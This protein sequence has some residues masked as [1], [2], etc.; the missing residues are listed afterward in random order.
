MSGTGLIINKQR[1][2]CCFLEIWTI[3]GT[4]SEPWKFSKLK[5]PAIIVNLERISQEFKP[6]CF[7]IPT[8]N[9]KLWRSNLCLYSLGVDLGHLDPIGQSYRDNNFIF[10]LFMFL[11][12]FFPPAEI[13]LLGQSLCKPLAKKKGRRIVLS[14]RTHAGKSPH[15]TQQ[16]WLQKRC[17]LSCL[18]P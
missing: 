11:F 2:I 4:P 9:K 1:K 16:G 8:G 6:L 3:S 12:I 14:L 13:D 7:F 17:R 15:F 5:Q 18:L 10:F